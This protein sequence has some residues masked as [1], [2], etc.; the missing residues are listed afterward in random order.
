MMEEEI[1]GLM[2]LFLSLTVLLL[3]YVDAE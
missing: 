3:L 2:R 1:L